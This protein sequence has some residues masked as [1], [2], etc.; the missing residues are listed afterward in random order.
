MTEAYMMHQTEELKRDAIE[1][2][3]MNSLLPDK[4]DEDNTISLSKPKKPDQSE[5]RGGF[6]I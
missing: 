5:S 4:E 2:Y 1:K 6:K 3:S